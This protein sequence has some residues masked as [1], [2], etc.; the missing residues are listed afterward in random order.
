MA[1]DVRTGPFWDFVE[2]R[3]AP[4]PVAALLGFELVA[5]DPD[6]GT[7][8]VGFTATDQFRNPV[9]DVQG[10]ILGAMLDDTLG[11]CLVATLGPEQWA[12][13]LELHTHYLA[14]ARVGR[15][16]GHARVVQRGRSVAFLA[17][18]LRQGDV[19]VATATA[20]ALIRG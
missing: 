14:P 19:V 9:G 2:G 20:T 13:T 1:T 5:V 8:E 4:P 16:V 3:A 10:G 18:E 12:P 15:L 6:A 17:G 11:P 7:I